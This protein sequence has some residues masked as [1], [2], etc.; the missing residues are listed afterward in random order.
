[1]RDKEQDFETKLGHW[2]T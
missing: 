1:M 2:T